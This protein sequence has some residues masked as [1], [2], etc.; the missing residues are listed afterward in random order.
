LARKNLALNKR[1]KSLSKLGAARKYCLQTSRLA[2]LR[3]EKREK[4]KELHAKYLQKLQRAIDKNDFSPVLAGNIADVSQNQVLRL[5]KQVSA[6]VLYY[7]KKIHDL[8][9]LK[10]IACSKFLTN[11]LSQGGGGGG[12]HG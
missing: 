12:L 8:F 9:L 7:K 4:L 1:S 2:Q 11:C 6:L 10:E 5:S 3:T